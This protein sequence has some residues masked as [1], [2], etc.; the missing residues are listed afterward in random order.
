MKA[1]PMKYYVEIASG[2]K[3]CMN[4]CDQLGDGTD[5]YTN[6]QEM[7]DGYIQ[8]TS[9]C[10]DASEPYK[11]QKNCISLC[12][13][14]T[15]LYG[16]RCLYQCPHAHKYAQNRTCVQ[17]CSSG[18]YQNISSNG[19]YYP[20]CV[21][22]CSGYLKEN[23]DGMF[24]CLEFCPEEMY[25][26]PVT[27]GSRTTQYC[28]EVCATNCSKVRTCSDDC[29]SPGMH[30]LTDINFIV[31]YRSQC[32]ENGKFEHLSGCV[33]MCPQP[34]HWQALNGSCRSGCEDGEY[35]QNV[36]RTSTLQYKCVRNC[37][38]DAPIFD[39]DVGCTV[40]CPY[41]IYRLIKS[42][43]VPE[44]QRVCIANCHEGLLYMEEDIGV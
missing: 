34:R 43:T 41:N 12:P 5:L 7:P 21:S 1:C 36:S 30:N 29:Y 40:A 39:P 8:C 28:V 6:K 25:I 15:Y 2:Y 37:S 16:L 44:G 42:P 13:S 20:T 3:Y 19:K 10:L 32:V 17:T 31:K 18:Y 9:Q 35:W 38:Y 11:F 4:G 14:G 27:V 24:E 22:S 26:N 23:A 33:S